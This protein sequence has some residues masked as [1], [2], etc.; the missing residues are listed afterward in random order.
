MWKPE[1]PPPEEVEASF[2]RD[3]FDGA[4]GALDRALWI[5]LLA[6]REDLFL[7]RGGEAENQ[8][9]EIVL[10]WN[11]IGDDRIAEIEAR[12]RMYD[13]Q[14]RLGIAN[15]TLGD[16]SYPELEEHWR[17]ERD[18][19]IA[20]R[21]DFKSLFVFGDTLIASYI[22]MSE[23]VWE[24]PDGI[25]HHDGTTA[26]IRSVQRA[27]EGGA[28]PAPF[29][30]YMEVVLDKLVAV[31]RLLGFYRD[32]FVVH[33]PPD[34]LLA[35]GGGSLA[36]P[37]DFHLEHAQRREVAEAELR[38]LRRTVRQV[39]Q[40]EGLDLGADEPEP[41]A[42]PRRE[43]AREPDGICRCTRCHCRT[44]L[45]PIRRRE[46]VGSRERPPEPERAPRGARAR[47][48]PAATSSSGRG[49]PP[50]RAPGCRG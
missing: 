47:P 5:D 3:V 25:N 1:I 6:E 2:P 28:L 42:Q 9:E 33:L 24:A 30:E 35:G 19:E 29:S 15:Y 37:L 16:G 11:R 48:S 46:R 39:E 41:A 4:V 40:A 36:V 44:S 10:I 31:D 22:T 8:L 45:S 12:R 27:Q 20:L 23:P 26:F 32:K 18:A 7:A 14:E 13:V 43:L 50:R 17:V 21:V 49:G 38:S 34:M